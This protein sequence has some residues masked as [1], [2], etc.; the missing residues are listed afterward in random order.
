MID[1]CRF[2][3]AAAAFEE[4]E[5]DKDKVTKRFYTLVE[6]ERRRHDWRVLTIGLVVLVRTNESSD[7]QCL[8]LWA[9]QLR[10][11]VTVVSGCT[12]E[13]CKGVQCLKRS[14]G[15]VILPDILCTGVINELHIAGTPR[16]VTLE[17]AKSK[18]RRTRE[19]E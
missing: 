19:K 4:E 3:L 18:K 15:L 16:S 17:D 14:A 10:R 13:S 6:Q 9:K 7:W 1:G 5:R 2:G 11:A 8:R 12:A